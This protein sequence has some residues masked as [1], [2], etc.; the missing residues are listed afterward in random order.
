MLIV[1]PR[2]TIDE[3][4]KCVKLV[5]MEDVYVATYWEATTESDNDESDN[6]NMHSRADSA[7]HYTKLRAYYSYTYNRC[8]RPKKYYCPNGNV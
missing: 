7:F 5:A 3:V 4:V 2:R 6:D 8:H 1:Y